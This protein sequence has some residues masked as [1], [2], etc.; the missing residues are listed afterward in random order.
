MKRLVVGLLAHVD[1][2]KT[3]LAE[4]LLYQTGV[5]RKPGRVDHQDAFLDN[6]AL[7]RERGITIFSKQVE[8]PWKDMRIT[9]LDTPGHVDFST[10]TERTLQVLDYA[11]LIISGSEG[12]QSH[13]KTLWGL[14][15]TYQIPTFIFVNKMDMQ[16]V[17][18]QTLLSELNTQLHNVFVDFTRR[19]TPEFYEACAMA[20]EEAIEHFLGQDKL[21]DEQIA[22]EIRLRRLFPCFFGSALRLEG[23]EALLDGILAYTKAPVY[24]DSFGARVYKISRDARG[25]KLVHMKLTG[26]SLRVKSVIETEGEAEKVNELRIY[27]GERYETADEVQAGMICAV[28]GLLRA[29]AGM[30]LGAEPDIPHGMLEPVLRYRVVP[31][32]EV[33]SMV[34]YGWL[35]TL[36]EE[37]SSLHVTWREDS[38]EIYMRLM[39]LVQIEVLKRIIRDRFGVEV[40]FDE[41]SIMYRETIAAPVKGMGHYEPLR[42]YAEVQLLLEPLPPGSG[43]EFGTDCPEDVLDRNWQRLVLTHLAEREHLGVLTGSPITDMR[44]T[45]LTGRAHNKHTEGG[46]FR[47]ATYRAVRQGLKSAESVLLE[48]IYRFTL[49]LPANHVGHAMSDIERMCGHMDAPNITGDEAELTGTA[50]VAAMGNYQAELSAYTGGAGKCFLSAG[51]YMPCH[52]AEAVIE[53]VGYDS[54]QDLKN[55]T[56][57]VFCAHGAGYLVPWNEVPKMVHMDSGYVEALDAAKGCVSEE[58]LQKEP[59]AGAGYAGRAGRRQ[60][61]LAGDEYRGMSGSAEEDKELEAIFNR[62]FQS[63]EDRGQKKFKNTSR[64][65]G[66]ERMPGAAGSAGGRKEERKRQP[67]P[68]LPQCLLVDGY[69]VIF[70]WPALAKLAETDL[71]AARQELK[72]ILSN[73]QGFCGSIV[74]LVFDAYKVKGNPGSVEKYHNIHVV[75]TKEAETADMFIE[76]TTHE[77]SKKYDIT[78]A[79]SDALE[80]LIVMGQGG[81]RISSKDLAEEIKRVAEVNMQAFS[82]RQQVF[83]RLQ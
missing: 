55:P 9:M 7:E 22:E 13:T 70:A 17:D 37:D 2:G 81:R 38:S 30:G 12:I 42:H 56:C 34:L 1:A 36:S 20:S 61:D 77:N 74:I 31:P 33:D 54:E 48:P 29:R 44:I 32:A 51:G 8:L 40:D 64:A 24:P 25:N 83:E 39:G 6:N 14:L 50:P 63:G 41:G 15:K 21:T 18:K 59:G 19:D 79:T 16:G 76:K 43:L 58:A 72:D 3:T 53:E 75:Y 49:R 27:S 65:L 67:K 45:L 68:R 78:V 80:Q 69:N 60:T 28:T 62:T 26:G 5:I 52:N 57:S 71:G 10:E 66:Y 73:Y 23:I 4:G 82:E 46:D 11:V 35:K 47:Q